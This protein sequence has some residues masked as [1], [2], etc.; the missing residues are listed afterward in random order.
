MNYR[1]EL[2]GKLRNLPLSY[3]L[4]NLSLPHLILESVV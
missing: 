4:R 1:G 3:L 2:I